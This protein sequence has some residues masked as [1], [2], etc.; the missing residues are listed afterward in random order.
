MDLFRVIRLYFK[1]LYFATYAGIITP[2]PIV[3]AYFGSR[4]AGIIRLRS[5]RRLLANWLRGGLSELSARI[6][7]GVKHG[8][9]RGETAAFPAILVPMII[10]H[11]PNLFDDERILL[12]PDR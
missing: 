11:P 3:L 5:E 10:A 2:D 4:C 7:D 1:G 9:S 8:C 12:T 6:L